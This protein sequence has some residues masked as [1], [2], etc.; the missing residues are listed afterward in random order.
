[1]TDI[2]DHSFSGYTNTG[3]TSYQFNE[4]D[5]PDLVLT[6]VFPDKIELIYTQNSLVTYT[7]FDT[8]YDSRAVFKVVYSCV[9]GKWHESERIYGTIVPSTQESY[10]FD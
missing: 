2:K 3:G 6:S 1:M 4:W 9:D 8:N 7:H 5:L 10:N